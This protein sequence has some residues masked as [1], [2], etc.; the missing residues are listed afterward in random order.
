MIPP[1]PDLRSS[2]SSV[3]FPSADFRIPT[4]SVHADQKR[5]TKRVIV[6]MNNLHAETVRM[7]SRLRLSSFPH[8]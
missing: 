2:G 8:D 6:G 1:L 3:D 4:Q 5:P 7:A